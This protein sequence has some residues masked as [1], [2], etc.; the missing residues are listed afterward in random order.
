MKKRGRKIGKRMVREREGRVNNITKVW[1]GFNGFFGFGFGGRIRRRRETEPPWQSG[2]KEVIGLSYYLLYIRCQETCGVM[3]QLEVM[4]SAIQLSGSHPRQENSGKYITGY[5]AEKALV[6]R[7]KK[8]KDTLS[9][10][11]VGGDAVGSRQK[12]LSCRLTWPGV[13]SEH[14]SGILKRCIYSGAE[15]RH[16]VN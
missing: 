16:R 10:L 4:G 2:T 12:L 8:K 13:D 9:C 15:A 7:A 1:Y 3:A 5:R 14:T 11:P 6:I